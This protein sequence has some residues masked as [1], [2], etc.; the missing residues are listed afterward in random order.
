M[1]RTVTCAIRKNS[2][3][4]R[5]CRGGDKILHVKLLGRLR[6][7]QTER[8]KQLDSHYPCK[9]FDQRTAARIQKEVH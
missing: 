9:D 2:L 4:S 1:N 8:S 7:R 5:Q 6:V 3:H